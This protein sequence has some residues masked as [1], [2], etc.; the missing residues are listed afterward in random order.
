LPEAS[1]ERH[2]ECNS[3]FW[4]ATHAVILGA[5]AALTT[6]IGVGRYILWPIGV[7]F[8]KTVWIPI[9]E[10]W[11]RI[12]RRTVVVLPGGLRRNFWQKGMWGQ[13]PC[14][15][16]SMDFELT[17]VTDRPVKMNTAWLHFRRWGLLRQKRQGHIAV[18]RA[19][20]DVFGEYEITPHRSAAA[21]ANWMIIPP[22]VSRETQRFRATVAFIDQYGNAN[23]CPRIKIG[24][25]GL[26]PN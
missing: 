6:I 14:T 9:V 16:V 4:V 20:T 21:T 3:I 18:Q 2:R 11:R 24:F 5:L 15:F 8:C 26:W 25:I 7:W 23:W 12:P 19:R 13:T 10:A 22:L 1:D 17:N